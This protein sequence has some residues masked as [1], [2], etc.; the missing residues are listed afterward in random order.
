M[1]TYYTYV[2]GSS[3]PLTESSHLAPPLPLSS[4]PPLGSGLCFGIFSQ[5]KTNNNNAR[6]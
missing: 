1:L 3:T 2:S 5:V 4:N 6:D